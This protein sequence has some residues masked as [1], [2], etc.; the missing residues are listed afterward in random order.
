MLFF[1]VQ[2]YPPSLLYILATL[3]P[4]LLFLSLVN[5]RNI[6]S[7]SPFVII[8]RVPFFYYV[9]HIY[10]IHFIAVI[11][12]VSTGHPWTDMV[13]TTFIF[14]APQLKGTYGLSLLWV[15]VIWLLVI[16]IIYPLCK[17]YNNFKHQHMNWQWLSYL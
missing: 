5:D 10:L 4:V 7:S 16:V 6:T 13:T 17:W 9:L 12:A 15:Y 1:N 8:G 2:K 11:V 3:G 14:N